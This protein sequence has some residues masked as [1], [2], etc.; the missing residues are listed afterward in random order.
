LKKKSSLVVLKFHLI[1]LRIFIIFIFKKIKFKFQNS[2]ILEFGP[3]RFHRILSNFNEIRRICEPWCRVLP[4][5][6][7]T[8]HGHII[9]VFSS[10]IKGSGGFPANYH[11][12]LLLPKI[13]YIMMEE[14]GRN[15]IPLLNLL[16][17]TLPMVLIT[18]S[19]ILSVYRAIFLTILKTGTIFP[20]PDSSTYWIKHCL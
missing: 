18:M 11:F 16:Q 4:W 7:T 9:I 12:V 13:N 3:D 1:F 19:S 14:R 15:A 2:P 10:L 5:T 17:S 6:R 20:I 8:K